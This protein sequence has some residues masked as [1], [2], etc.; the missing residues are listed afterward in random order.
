[1]TTLEETS[2]IVLHWGDPETTRASLTRLRSCYPNPTAPRVVVV[3][4][5]SARVFLEGLAGVERIVLL[6][7][8]GYGAGNNLGIRFARQYGTDFFVLM[9]NDVV[10]SAGALEALCRAASIQGVGL[11]GARLR[12][13]D[14]EV[15]GGGR[16]QWW[17]LRARL[18]RA[19]GRPESLDYIHGACLGLRARCLDAVG[20]LREDFFLYWEDVEYGFRVR[21]A[22]FALAVADTPLLSHRQDAYPVELAEKTYY[23]VRNAILCAHAVVPRYVRWWAQGTLPFRRFL[24]LCRGKRVVALALRDAARGVTGPAPEEVRR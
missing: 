5:G 24:A 8:V 15:W 14:G 4:N 11:V 13:P 17:R 23:L 18:A 6:R 22:G 16:V 21:R 1:M 12:E 10:L 7:N 2:V 3:E 19:E 9:N 20:P